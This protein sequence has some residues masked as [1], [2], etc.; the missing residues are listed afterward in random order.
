MKGIPTDVISGDKEVVIED[1][2]MCE[3]E[4]KAD[5]GISVGAVVCADD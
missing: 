5:G 2:C 4:G 3:Y 1:V